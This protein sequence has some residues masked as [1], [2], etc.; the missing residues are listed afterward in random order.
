MSAKPTLAFPNAYLETDEP[1]RTFPWGKVFALVGVLGIASFVLTI[2]VLHLEP[3]GYDPVVRAV[4]E[5]AVGAYSYQMQFGF[6]VGGLGLGSL[7]VASYVTNTDRRARVGS[8][9]LFFSGV[10]LF[11]VGA[12]PTDLEGAQA[13]FHGTVHL[14]LSAVVFIASP[15]AMLMISSAISRKWLWATLAA[16]AAVVLIASAEL[17]LSVNYSGV[18]ERI[19][20][21]VMVAWWTLASLRILRAS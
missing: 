9:L 5:Y 19:Y 16:L 8:I 14:A 12:F 21:G 11:A 10:A 3:T 4:S 1:P 15:S 20:I 6:F 17:P 2:A 18:V 13:T 7:G